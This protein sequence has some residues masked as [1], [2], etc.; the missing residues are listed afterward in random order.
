MPALGG[1]THVHGS[2]R[3]KKLLETALDEMIQTGAV[4][5]SYSSWAFPVVLVPKKDSTARLCVDYRCLNAVTVR[6][7]YP[8]PSIELIIYSLGDATVFT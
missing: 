7:S 4:R 6:D 5:K 3:K 8:F 1:V 2:V